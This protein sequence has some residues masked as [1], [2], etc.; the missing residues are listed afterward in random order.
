[1]RFDY[2]ASIIVYASFRM[3]NILENFILDTAGDF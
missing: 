3:W 1:V 2:V